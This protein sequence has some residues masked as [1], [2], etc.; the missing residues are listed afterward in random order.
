MRTIYVNYTN[1][2]NNDETRD[3]FFKSEKFTV[4]GDISLNIVLKRPFS[5]L[6][7]GITAQEWDKLMVQNVEIKNS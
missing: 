3:A 2:S 5:Q 1:A 7:V 4:N 6:N